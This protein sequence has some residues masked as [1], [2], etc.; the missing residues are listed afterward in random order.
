MK[1]KELINLMPKNKDDR[2]AANV[3]VKLGASAIEPVWCDM[4]L[5]LRVHHQ[6]VRFEHLWTTGSHA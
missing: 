1:R 5:W 3:I 4:L 6:Q 2:N